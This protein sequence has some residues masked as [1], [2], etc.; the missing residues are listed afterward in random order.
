MKV[1]F[2]KEDYDIDLHY[3]QGH[4]GYGV[5]VEGSNLVIFF[6]K[7]TSK[8]TVTESP[9]FI[10]KINPL[11]T[12]EQ[13]KEEEDLL[14]QSITHTRI[15]ITNTDDDTSIEELIAETKKFAE[16]E[17]AIL[18]KLLSHFPEEEEKED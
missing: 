17:K 16:Q 6:N 2:F 9:D 11:F 14:E 4:T 10:K 3:G 12:Q 7:S 1:L 13:I 8:I 15:K 5:I 18:E